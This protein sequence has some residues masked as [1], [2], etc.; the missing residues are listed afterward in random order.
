[1]KTKA[2][3]IDD[4]RDST[5]LLKK[6]LQNYPEIDEVN[7][8]ND[9]EKGY[10]ALKKT[11]PD[12]LFLD[13][14]MSGLSGIDILGLIQT[15]NIH[16]HVIIIT[17]HERLIIQAA[18]YSLIDYLLKPFSPEE[19]KDSLYKYFQHKEHHTINQKIEKFL[20]F[21][22]RK[23]RIP[24]SF[25]ELF[26]APEEIYYLEAD[27]NYTNI[28]TP[29]GNKITSSFHLGKIQQILPGDIFYRISRK[30]IINYNYLKKID[31]RRKVV[32]LNHLGK[33]IPYSKRV[34]VLSGLLTE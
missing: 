3:I 20:G 4:E 6:L 29:D 21:Q 16:V 23:I 31:K 11:E 27:G 24:T 25:E 1:M 19:L 17:A 5:L 26:F 7:S 34:I 18:R 10:E 28:Y 32:Y 8:F 12:I 15:N 30:V 22:N 9:S 13:L 33:E 2:L 14:Q